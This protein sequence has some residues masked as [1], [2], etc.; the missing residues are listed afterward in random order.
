MTRINVVPVKELCDQ[1]LLAEW[2]E[3]PRIKSSINKSFNRK[4][5][6]FSIQEIPDNYVL[7]KGHVKFFFNKL[8]YLFKRHKELTEEC[9]KRGI[10]L[11]NRESLQ[12]EF[13]VSYMN[14]YKPTDEALRINRERIKERM[15]VK[16]RYSGVY[17]HQDIELL[18]L[19]YKKLG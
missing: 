16:P 13:N 10:N 15:P 11:N 9:I 4:N 12:F 8:I 7:G 17:S 5:K 6:P 2:R 3:L 19:G 14:D 18:N 1:H